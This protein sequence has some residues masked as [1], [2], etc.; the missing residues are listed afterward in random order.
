MYKIYTKILCRQ[1]RCIHKSLLIMRLTAFL[2]IT[3]LLQVSAAS[4]AQKLTMTKNNS[5]FD[6]VFREIR[7]QTGYDVLLISKK[8]K[9]TERVDVKFNNTPL[10]K[11]MDELLKGKNLNYTIDKK[12]VVIKEK[13]TTLIDHVINSLSTIDVKGKVVNENNEGL[14]GATIAVKG[15]SKVTKTNADGDFVLTNVDE[16]AML[17]VSYIGFQVKE[18][19]AARDLKVIRMTLQTSDLNEVNIVMTGYQDLNKRLFTG[20]SSKIKAS[21]AERA[22][23]P[24]VSR[25]LEGQVAGVSVQNV[26]GTFGAAP[27]IRVRGA[28]S[29]NG[30]NKPLWVVDG[31]ILEDVVNISNEQLSTGDPST[32]VGSSVAGLNPDDI[33]SFE[34]LKD[35]SATAMYGARAMNGVIVVTTKKGKKTD[36]KP[37]LS[38]TGNFTTYLK[39]SYNQYDIMNSANQM[40]VYAEMMN[41]G[42]LNH[43]EVSRGASGG[44]F[45]KMYNQ[46]YQYDAA[47]DEF[48]LRNDAPSRKEFLK[49][50]AN[51]NTDWFDLLFKNSF[52]QEH[53]LS[54]TS[55]TDKSKFYISTSYLGDNGWTV[56]NSVDRFTGNVR[57]TFDLSSKLTIEVI[58]QGS[59]RNQFTPGSLGRRSSPSTG[60]FTR[61]FDINPFTYALNTSRTLT[62]FDEQGNK[63]FFVQNFAPFNI[64]HEL[65]NN[66]MQLKMLDFKLQGGLKYKIING[67]KYSFDAA[68]RYVKSDNEHRI[69]DNSNM[70]MAYRAAGDS[71]VI[72]NNKFL[73]K[74]PDNPNALP[75][76]ILPAGGFYNVNSDNMENYYMRNSLEWNKEYNND[77]LFNAFLS[78]E[79]RFT[80]RQ[81][82][83]FD[84]VGYQYDR[85]GVPFIDPDYFKKSVESNFFYY[86]MNTL[87][88]RYLSYLGRVAYAYKG[89]YSVN[90]TMRYDGSNLLGG[91]TTARWLPTWNISGAWNIDNE[92]FFDKQ[93]ILSRATLRGTY[94]LTASMG[95]ATNASL[96]LNN[97]S[98]K[99]PFLRDIET[100]LVIGGLKNSELTW[101]K[102]LETNIGFDLGFLKDRLSLTVDLYK[103]NGY[104]LIGAVRTSGIGGQYIKYAN[105]ADMKSKGIEVTTAAQILNGAGLKW[106]TQLNFG[107]HKGKI[108]K[109]ESVPLVWSLISPGGDALQGYPQRGLFSVQFD[110]LNPQTG[111]PTFV[112]VNGE[113]N[114]TNV[115]L[116]DD[117]IGH[118]K[119]E[120]PTDPLM[121]GGFFNSFSYKS[122]SLSTLLTFSAGNK[123]RLN[124]AF[125]A[126]YNDLSSMSNDFVGRWMQPGDELKTNIPAIADRFVQSNLGSDYPYNVYNYSD[127]RVADGGFIRIKQIMLSYNLPKLIS[128]KIGANNASVSVVGNNLGLLYSDKRL[129]GQDPEFYTSGGVS[130]PVPRQFTVS[131]KLG[132]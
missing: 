21:D 70:P 124:P 47:T 58:T 89:K 23:V 93:D 101:E 35:A 51:A 109:L 40:S 43:S 87:K 130:L 1:S 4:F 25:M 110:G 66:T 45:Y 132:F 27:K 74:D 129:N 84:G 5:S 108:T 59:I 105:Y 102:Q 63:E 77:H 6:E 62:A 28:T 17:V 121:N 50:Y 118:L 116:Q 88:E 128:G 20:A 49:R 91:T 85:G 24:D 2:L 48:N 119:Y 42:W 80:D 71:Y 69:N 90:G 11:V 79:M 54:I 112:G 131:L 67:L 10:D 46:M 100:A 26:S 125:S 56:G 57:G 103:R 30:E 120:G 117:N 61:E 127:V 104:D 81:R 75:R 65:E 106:R 114:V 115:Y 14:A 53:A 95:P 86:N 16:N 78:T 123:I 36:G 41:K 126:S 96:I 33:E 113:R 99:R 18:I 38:Y 111:I 8:V 64:L 22:G 44:V 37:V 12:T 92:E 3:T 32:L 97:Q 73:Y 94:G 19:K 52:M 31:I 29:I 83:T 55:G 15:S 122:F 34:I 39:P 98:T 82:R 107:Y 7:K 13:E 76:V 68:Y 9:S 72:A 60:T